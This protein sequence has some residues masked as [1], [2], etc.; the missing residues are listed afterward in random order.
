MSETGKIGLTCLKYCI[1]TVTIRVES[2]SDMEQYSNSLQ[3]ISEDEI[4][5]WVDSFSIQ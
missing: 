3:K 2:N 1:F 5:V 4:G